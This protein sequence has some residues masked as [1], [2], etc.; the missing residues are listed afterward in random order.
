VGRNFIG[1]SGKEFVDGIAVGE[2][3]VGSACEVEVGF[4]GVDAKVAVERGE[5]ILWAQGAFGG[6]APLESDAPMARP[7]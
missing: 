4:V 6:S 3:G 5:H 7:P 2:D 1:L